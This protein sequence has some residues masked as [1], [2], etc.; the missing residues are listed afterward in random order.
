MLAKRNVTGQA[1]SEHP[2]ECIA[3]VLVATCDWSYMNTKRRS[4]NLAS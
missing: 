3:M 4:I 2:D 1:V